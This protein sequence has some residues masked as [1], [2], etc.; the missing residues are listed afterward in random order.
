MALSVKNMLGGGTVE[1]TNSIENMVYAHEGSIEKNTFVEFQN[2]FGDMLRASGVLMTKNSQYDYPYQ[3][4]Y[5]LGN[6]RFILL[7]GK[8]STPRLATYQFA[9]GRVTLL[10]D[11]VITTVSNYNNRHM[12][13]PLEDGTFLLLYSNGPA[14]KHRTVTV[15]NDGTIV[16]GVEKDSDT[17]LVL[18]YDFPAKAN[19]YLD[20]GDGYYIISAHVSGQGYEYIQLVR[21]DGDS[22]SVLDSRSFGSSANAYKVMSPGCLH[23]LDNNKFVL[24]YPVHSSYYYAH[25]VECDVSSRTSIVLGTDNAN[26][27]V[28]FRSLAI[29]SDG[30]DAFL[31]YGQNSD[32]TYP[33]IG[34]YTNS[35]NSVGNLHTITFS[36]NVICNDIVFVGGRLYLS[37]LSSSTRYLWGYDTKTGQEIARISVDTSG[38]SQHSDSIYVKDDGRIY[39]AIEYSSGIYLYYINAEMFISEASSRIDGLLVSMASTTQKGKVLELKK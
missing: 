21:Y 19:S 34:K 15:D 38:Y 28:T 11:I 6:E 17:S 37:V 25:W 13:I 20:M 32:G 39:F 35:S 12:M 36:N 31:F 33:T 29:S 23:K 26:T 7:F 4:I 8:T 3:R 1:V 30:K 14:P 5:S 27:S 2:E 22:L 10:N 9:D 16:L 18:G 24:F